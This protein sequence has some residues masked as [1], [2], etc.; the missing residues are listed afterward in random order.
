M[1]VV[2]RRGFREKR[3]GLKNNLHN[4]IHFG[5]SFR[6]LLSALTVSPVPSLCALYAAASFSMHSLDAVAWST[7]GGG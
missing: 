1:R 4:E 6:F 3:F 2:V 7:I 5:A